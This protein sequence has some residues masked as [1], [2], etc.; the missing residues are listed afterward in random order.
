MNAAISAITRTSRSLE[1]A[2]TRIARP[3]TRKAKIKLGITISVP[4]FLKIAFDYTADLGEPA[5]DNRPDR[6]PRRTA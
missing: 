1:R 2:V 3:L 4:P 5:N 6:Q